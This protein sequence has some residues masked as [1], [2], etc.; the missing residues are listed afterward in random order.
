MCVRVQSG[1]VTTIGRLGD[2]EHG[3]VLA[4]PRKHAATHVDGLAGLVRAAE[5]LAGQQNT[6]VTTIGR[7]GAVP[8]GSKLGQTHATATS[9]RRCAEHWFRE[10]VDHGSVRRDLTKSAKPSKRNNLRVVVPPDDDITHTVNVHVIG[11]LGY[12]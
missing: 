8:A 7:L 4:L 5:H 3:A 11:S 10:A 12:R 9:A 6:D 1:A 2:S